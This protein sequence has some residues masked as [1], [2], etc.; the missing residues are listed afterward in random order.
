V[1]AALLTAGNSLEGFFFCGPEA[2]VGGGISGAA[3]RMAAENAIEHLKR[4]GGVK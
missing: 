2:T 4:D 1:T 3:G